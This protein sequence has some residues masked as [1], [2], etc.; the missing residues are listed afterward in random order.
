MRSVVGFAT[1]VLVLALPAPASALSYVKLD[2]R[3]NGMYVAG[4]PTAV[5]C[6]NGVLDSATAWCRAHG[7]NR[8]TNYKT[9]AVRARGGAW[10][11]QTGTA[12][13]DPN[14][15]M[16]TEITC[17]NQAAAAPPAAP[18]AP[19]YS[20]VRVNR[21]YMNGAFVDWCVNWGS[22]CGANAAYIVCQRLGYRGATNW[23]TFR[24]GRT[25]VMGANRYCQGAGCV[26]FDYVICAR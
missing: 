1:A 17:T 21:P 19:A 4:C 11:M 6:R 12:C 14:C 16:F 26:G 15:I 5:H 23:S 20:L 10:H 18:S 8:A 7:M 25:F 22:N 24:P 2:P 9:D 3:T 13:R